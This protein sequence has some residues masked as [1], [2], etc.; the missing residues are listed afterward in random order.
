[1]VKKTQA[2]VVI[3]VV[4]KTH[5]WVVISVVKRAVLGGY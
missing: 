4:K 3:N 1:V 5:F 2:W